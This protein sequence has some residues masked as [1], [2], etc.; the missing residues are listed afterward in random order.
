MLSHVFS[1]FFKYGPFL[2]CSRVQFELLLF[3]LYCRRRRR[4]ASVVCKRQFARF[5]GLRLRGIVHAIRNI[6]LETLVLGKFY[7]ID[8]E[9]FIITFHVYA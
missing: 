9:S 3:R 7:T 4:A 5:C 8:I 1:L 6:V 2:C